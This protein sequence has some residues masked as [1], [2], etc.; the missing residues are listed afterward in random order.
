MQDD[1]FERKVILAHNFGCFRSGSRT[2]LLGMWWSQQEPVAET[3]CFTGV[4]REER[5]GKSQGPFR[6]PQRPHFLPWACPGGCPP[7][8]TARLGLSQRD[9][10]PC[11]LLKIWATAEGPR[12][13]VRGVYQAQHIRK[14][15]IAL[16]LCAP[17][18]IATKGSK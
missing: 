12:L 8:T 13:M 10:S 17:K 14:H 16:I 4:R 1:E 7:P 5:K 11:V 2:L 6:L 18:P 15:N 9:M 3:V